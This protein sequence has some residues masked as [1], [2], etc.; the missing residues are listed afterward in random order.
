[1][2]FQRFQGLVRKQFAMALFCVLAIA[3]VVFAQQSTDSR[4]DRLFG[5]FQGKTPGCAVGVLHNGEV[6][7]AKAYGMADL[8]RETPLSPD[9]PFYMA[10]VSKQFT[11]MSVLL[12]AEDGK[13]Q[14]MDSVRKTLP[15][16]PE[17]ANQITLYHLLTHTSGVRDYLTLGTLSGNSPDFVH[18]D[19]GVLRAMSR[20]SALN[21][22]PGSEFIY[23]NSGYLLLSLVVKQVAGKNLNAFAQGRIFGPLGIKSTRFQHDH[24][25]LIPGKA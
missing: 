17:Y 15:E 23:S 18:T 19:R 6:V 21:F 8:E 16:L 11:A 12:L 5:G 14:T 22:A 25:A 13:L 2:P 10:S 3:G 20:Q 4:V 7:L 24:S 1:M 9:T